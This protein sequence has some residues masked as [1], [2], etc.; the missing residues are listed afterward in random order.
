MADVLSE[1]TDV[2][3]VL[4]KNGQR[5]TVA[6]DARLQ[7][8]LTRVILVLP[9]SSSP[10]VFPHPRDP[11]RPRTAG[12]NQRWLQGLC[13][14]AGVAGPQCHVHASGRPPRRWLE[15]DRRSAAPW[16]LASWKRTTAW[17]TRPWH[18]SL[19]GFVD[20]AD[21]S[22]WIGHA[23]LQQTDDYWEAHDGIPRVL[24]L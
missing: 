21:V 1:P 4:E 10:Y 7:A 11:Q 19:Q 15:L 18:G 16:S 17:A 12:Q 13:R 5:R 6:L 8:A 9:Q 14:R 2:V 23:T 24:S 3:T 20:S 22:A